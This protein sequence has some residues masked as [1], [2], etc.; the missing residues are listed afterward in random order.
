MK[1]PFR[2]G[3]PILAAALLALA[4]A[5]AL[6]QE[7]AD[8]ASQWHPRWGDWSLSFVLPDGGAPGLGIWRQRTDWALGVVLDADLS[9]TVREQP[10]G[11]LEA[12]SLLLRFGPSF[13]RYWW[14]DGPA[15]PFFLFE[16]G[17]LYQRNALG[18][19]ATWR[20]GAD[21]RLGVGAEWFPME[22]IGIG[23]HTGLGGSW[24]WTVDDDDVDDDETLLNAGLFTSAL[25]VQ[26]YF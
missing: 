4:A 2:P 17:G 25:S 5:P 19:M 10:A 9:S 23:G 18:D 16:L 6:A 15:A 8:D 7:T 21:A 13:R 11:D 12:T 20:M 24:F 22:G 14:Q 26:I 1:H 3:T